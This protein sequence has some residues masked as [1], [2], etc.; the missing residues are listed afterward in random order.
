M[1][2]YSKSTILIF[3]GFEQSS[4]CGVYARRAAIDC[5][6]TL[7]DRVWG[8]HRP[9]FVAGGLGPSNVA[10]C[11]RMV[12]PMAVDASSGMEVQKVCILC[13]FVLL[14]YMC[15]YIYVYIYI[16]IYIYIFI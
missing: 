9:M 12:R 6:G 16:Y 7:R 8:A 11:V 1:N 5:V 10:D 13:V 15:V 2:F 3:Q 14:T 4:S